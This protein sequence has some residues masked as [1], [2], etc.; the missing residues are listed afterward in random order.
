M[1]AEAQSRAVLAH[2]RGVAA[3]SVSNLVS[4]GFRSR[5][6]ADASGDLV[7][8]DQRPDRPGTARAIPA[9]RLGP[10]SQRSPPVHASRIVRLLGR[11]AVCRKVIWAQVNRGPQ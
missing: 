8:R 9:K 2:P 7:L 1:D 11:S 6:V 5:L 3:S 10:R 4:I